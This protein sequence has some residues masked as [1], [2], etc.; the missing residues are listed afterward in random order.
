MTMD[1]MRSLPTLESRQSITA[2][3]IEREAGKALGAWGSR[4]TVG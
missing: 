2:A 3:T 4:L 1:R